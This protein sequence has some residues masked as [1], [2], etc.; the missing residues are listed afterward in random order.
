MI[1]D[2]ELL[3]MCLLVICLFWKNGYSVPLPILK[4][5][6][7]VFVIELHEFFIYFGYYTFIREM[8]CEYFLPFS[9]LPFILLLIS[10]AVQKL[11]FF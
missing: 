4:I 3:Y 11:F 1:S 9:R 7:F 8:I 2:V 5:R 6:L 10:F